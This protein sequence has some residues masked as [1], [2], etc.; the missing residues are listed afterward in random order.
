MCRCAP[1]RAAVLPL[2]VDRHLDDYNQSSVIRRFPAHPG[3]NATGRRMRP[4]AIVDNVQKSPTGSP[5]IRATPTSIYMG[6]FS[7]NVV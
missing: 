1:L 4:H 6:S 7:N 5:Q 2:F 3:G